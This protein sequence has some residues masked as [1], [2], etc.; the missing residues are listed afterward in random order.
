[1]KKT[2]TI[3]LLLA[4][5]L[6]LCACSDDS[7]MKA[8]EISDL[9]KISEVREWL[10]SDIWN[11]G[12]CDLSHYYY[13]GKSATGKSMDP[14]F[15]IEQLKKAY[16]KKAKYDEMMNSVSDEYSDLKEYYTKIMGQVDVLYAEI[17]S[18]GTTVTNKGLDTGLYSQYFDAFDDRY[19]EIKYD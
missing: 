7:G 16:A 12:I 3:A 1:M 6:L 17:L 8:P 4:M 14:E 10:V 15:S 9:E 2:I 13:N 11:D 5:V 19:F 18:R